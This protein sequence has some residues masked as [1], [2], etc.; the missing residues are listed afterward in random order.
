MYGL[1]QYW[2]HIISMVTFVRTHLSWLTIIYLAFSLYGCAN[3]DDL[4]PKPKSISRV[5]DY[6]HPAVVYTLV[7]E[8]LGIRGY[9]EPTRC[10]AS[11]FDQTKVEK[12]GKNYLNICFMTAAHCMDK[13]QIEEPRFSMKIRFTSRDKGANPDANREDSFTVEVDKQHW[14][15]HPAYNHDL[16]KGSNTNIHDI[17]VF[18]ADV[19]DHQINNLFKNNFRVIPLETKEG[20]VPDVESAQFVGSEVS[21]VGYG[22]SGPDDDSII[23]RWTPRVTKQKVQQVYPDALLMRAQ[24]GKGKICFGDS[25]MPAILSHNGQFINVGVFSKFIAG[26]DLPT[27]EY[28][29]ECSDGYTAFVRIDTHLDFIKQ[30]VAASR[31]GVKRQDITYTSINMGTCHAQRHIYYTVPSNIREAE[32]CTEKAQDRFEWVRCFVEAGVAECSNF[33][34]LQCDR[35]DFFKKN[36]AWCQP[37][38]DSI[39]FTADWEGECVYGDGV[40]DGICDHID[41]DCQYSAGTCNTPM[42][43]P[44]FIRPQ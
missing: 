34:D 38:L 19:E 42:Y 17:A 6:D 22:L 26:H 36:Q 41:P 44:G 33:A 12:D 18:C 1:A 32:Y 31:Q 43:Y 30:A 40:C 3:S 24:E 15:P 13:E 37:C 16:V 11:A 14:Y 29:P 21:T 2:L 8:N 28:F 23:T 7:Y 35:V 27:F 9:G 25:G 5:I 39:G 4:S 20:H 10:S